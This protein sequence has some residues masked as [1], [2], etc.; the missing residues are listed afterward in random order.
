[1]SFIPII[2]DRKDA[3]VIIGRLQLRDNKDVDH[4]I[5]L[6][7]DDEIYKCFKGDAWVC[8]FCK[9]CTKYLCTDYSTISRHCSVCHKNLKST[10][11]AIQKQILKLV[12][13]NN[14]YDI[15]ENLKNAGF[16]NAALTFRAGIIKRFQKYKEHNF[17]FNLLIGGFL[18]PLINF[19][20]ILLPEEDLPDEFKNLENKF[21]NYLKFIVPD[22]FERTGNIGTSSFLRRGQ[23][24]DTRNQTEI[25]KLATTSRGDETDLVKWWELKK[26][27]M[28]AL[29]NLS[30]KITTLRPTSSSIERVFSKGKYMLDDYTGAM[31][32]ENMSKRIFLYCNNDVSR[33]VIDEIEIDSL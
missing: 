31:T 28:P 30:K 2:L 26:D 16:V 23:I 10:E 4:A 19:Q 20:Q 22:A 14:L 33:K 3:F 1:M 15:C 27:E 11:N 18:N 29:Y 24:V 13:L 9:K 5:L 7:K 25:E 8:S 12:L 17:L 32:K 6:R 21:M